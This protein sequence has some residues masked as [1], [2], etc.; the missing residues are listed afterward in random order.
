MKRALLVLVSAFALV[1]GA[2]FGQGMMGPGW[3]GGP[4]GWGMMGGWWDARPPGATKAL[5]ID[6][7]VQDVQDY[8]KHAWGPDLKLVE[9]MEFDN[10]F[11]AAARE[12]STGIYAFELL[13]NMW[14]GAILPEPGPNMMWNAKYGHMGGGMMGGGWGWSGR[15]GYRGGLGADAAKGMPV[16]AEKAHELA[17][18]FLDAQLPGVT[19]EEDADAF[20]G[21]YTM[22]VMKDGKVYGMLSVNGFNGWVW[23]HTWHGKFIQ[24]KDLE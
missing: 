6:Q 14:T 22:D 4:P 13:V 1:A 20:Y 5:T 24:E 16:T 10:Q 11:Y 21:Y 17:Q 19:A 12:K 18:Q 15:P 23:Y 3:Q 7:A 8:L 2:T 9:V